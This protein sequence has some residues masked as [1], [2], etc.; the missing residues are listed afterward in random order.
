[1]LFFAQTEGSDKSKV[2]KKDWWFV[3]EKMII[4]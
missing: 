2:W 1:M 3:E 4:Q